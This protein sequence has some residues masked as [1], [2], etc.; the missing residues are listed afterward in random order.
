MVGVAFY[1]DSSLDSEI[2]NSGQRMDGPYFLSCS[3]HERDL[4]VDTFFTLDFG[5]YF[6]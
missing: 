2:R 4:F 3:S 5:S 1:L 6:R